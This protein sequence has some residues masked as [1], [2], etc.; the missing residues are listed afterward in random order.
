MMATVMCSSATADHLPTPPHD[1][2]N[3]WL[4]VLD[5][6]QKGV[7]VLSQNQSKLNPNA[8]NDTKKLDDPWHWEI[9]I[10]NPNANETTYPMVFEILDK[11][12]GTKVAFEPGTLKLGA[13]KDAYFHLRINE[14]DVFGKGVDTGTFEVY[15]KHLNKNNFAPIQWDMSVT[16]SD[17][18]TGN[19]HKIILPEA[20]VWTPMP[21]PEPATVLLG[22]IGLATLVAFRGQRWKRLPA[23]T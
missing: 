6:N 21:N 12:T 15:I 17:K 11:T 4:D 22:L 10:R 1:K 14:Q 5:P 16:E 18:L 19:D 2:Y 23:P 9:H 8:A 20:G 3:K 7:Y 13:G